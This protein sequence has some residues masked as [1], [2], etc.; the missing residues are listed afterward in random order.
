MIQV[1]A[2]WR[3]GAEDVADDEDGRVTKYFSIYKLKKGFKA[4]ISQ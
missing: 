4:S 2:P 1:I 3:L